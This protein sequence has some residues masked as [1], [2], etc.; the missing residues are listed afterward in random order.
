MLTNIRY[1][2]LTALRD[3]LFIGLLLGIV[4][5][6][7]ISHV[8]A[9]TALVE[10][11]EM[12]LAFGAG[13]A[14]MIL[15]IGLIVFVCFHIRH[16]FDSKEID[17][18]L[19]RPISRS[20]LILSYWL[21]F[22]TVACVLVIPTVAVIS[23]V[24][25]LQVEGFLVWAASLLCETFMVVAIALFAACTLRSAVASVMASLGFYVLSRMMG[26]FVAT[27]HSRMLESEWIDVIGKQVTVFI[28]MVIPRL[29]FFAKSEWLIYGVIS[30]QEV[31]LFFIQTAIF[32]PILLTAAIIDFN[33][34]QF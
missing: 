25:V 29:D 9:S 18:I 19:S 32:V 24:A 31:L 1:I 22:A 17:V 11:L 7:L 5:A 4:A 28:S 16:A 34:K 33:R 6:V 30:H 2:L 26:F 23:C 12:N 14:R 20:N 21:G 3:W 10:V 15:A 27:T 8:L 13:S